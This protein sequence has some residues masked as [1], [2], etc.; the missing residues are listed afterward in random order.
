MDTPAR[1]VILRSHLNDATFTS[2]FVVGGLAI[3]TTKMHGTFFTLVAAPIPTDSTQW[4]CWFP[5]GCSGS[6]KVSG[7]RGGEVCQSL[8][9]EINKASQDPFNGTPTDSSIRVAKFFL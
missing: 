9:K 7:Y 6:V 4:S 2:C 1:G 8:D 3:E 5:S